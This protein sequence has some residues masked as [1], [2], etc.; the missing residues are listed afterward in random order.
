MCGQHFSS[1][2]MP[3][4]WLSIASIFEVIVILPDALPISFVSLKPIVTA[5]HKSINNQLISGI[6]TCPWI[7]DEVW[8]TLT[9]GKQLNAEHCLMIEKVPV[10]MDWLPT[11]A[12]SMAITRTGHL[13][14]SE[15]QNSQIF[16][17]LENFSISFSSTLSQKDQ[18][19]LPTWY[20]YIKAKVV[21]LLNIMMSRK[22]R[23]LPHIR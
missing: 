6:Y 17:L 15:R 23:S 16:Q 19:I 21:L 20:R 2:K 1:G 22:I 7:L 12:A 14:F 18:I 13:N 9:L 11:T 4:S 5:K 3:S 10:M 8:T